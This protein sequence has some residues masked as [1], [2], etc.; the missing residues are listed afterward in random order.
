MKLVNGLIPS[1]LAMLAQFNSEVS[2]GIVHTRE[3]QLAMSILQETFN[4]HPVTTGGPVMRKP[5]YVRLWECDQT[6]P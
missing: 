6:A 1:E 2:R 4:S 5:W 3:Y